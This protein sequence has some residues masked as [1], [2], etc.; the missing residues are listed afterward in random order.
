MSKNKII[1]ISLLSFLLTHCD[2]SSFP[3]NID[4]GQNKVTAN[5]SNN[6]TK[7][8]LENNKISNSFEEHETQENL[9]TEVQKNLET[10]VQTQTQ[11]QENFEAQTQENFEENEIQKI[12]TPSENE[13]QSFKQI[14][15][16]SSLS[17]PSIPVLDYRITGLS[18][19]DYK[20]ICQKIYEGQQCLKD[21]GFFKTYNCGFNLK[22]QLDSFK[23]K[24][25][26]NTSSYVW[27]VKKYKEFKQRLKDCGSF[28]HACVRTEALEYLGILQ[29]HLAC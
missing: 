20:Q 2:P 6:K 23:Q 28:D 16:S 12:P 21:A 18:E 19:I 14:Q 9:E 17:P 13:A 22:T 10:E 29:I 3:E 1:Q 25:D 8:N 27:T 11:T 4:T 7:T 24:I 26:N 15:A 5:L